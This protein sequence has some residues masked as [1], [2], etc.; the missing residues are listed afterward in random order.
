MNR[1][2]VRL[3]IA[4]LLAWSAGGCAITGTAKDP[5]TQPATLVPATKTGLVLDTLPP[6]RQ[7]LDVAV[8]NFPDL[9]GQ[10]KSNDNFA[11]FSRAVTQGASSILTDVLVKAGNG[12]WFD[13]AERADLQSLLQERQIIQNT[14]T[15]LH[16]KNAQSLPPLRFAGVLL[17]GGIIGYDTNETTGGIGGNVSYRQDIVSVALRA[18]SVQTGRVLASVTTTKTIYSTS[19]GANAFQ[20]AAVDALLQVDLGVTK[21]SPATLAVR[22]GIQLAVYSLI[23][24]GVKSNLWEFR[25]PVAGAA[26]LRELE[27]HRKAVPPVA[28]IAEVPAADPIVVTKN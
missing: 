3:A 12:A 28:V 18:V 1:L 10:N 21:N 7:K 14:R 15:A 23:F 20:F 26:F 11:E 5:V 8:Y 22:E 27:L 24:E 6:P 19:V 13:V 25:D 17:D 4:S 2:V 16:G 9:T